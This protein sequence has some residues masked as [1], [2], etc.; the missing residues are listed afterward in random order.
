LQIL[1]EIGVEHVVFSYNFLPEGRDME[2]IMNISKEM[3]L[4][5]R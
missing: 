5:A 2:E 4:Y 1:K 3:A